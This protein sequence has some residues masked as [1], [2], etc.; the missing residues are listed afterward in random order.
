MGASSGVQMI[1]GTS[2]L[3]LYLLINSN[4]V[5]VV[6][7]PGGERVVDRSDTGGWAVAVIV[8]VA[9][10]AIGGFFAWRYYGAPAAAPAPNEA[11]N[12]NVTIPA[13]TGTNEEASAAQQ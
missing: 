13:P 8:L 11:T 5:T 3:C 4:M 6:N 9:L 1:C 12:I 7:S 10:V 2:T